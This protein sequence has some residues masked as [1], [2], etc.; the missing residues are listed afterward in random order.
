MH[1]LLVELGFVLERAV[2]GGAGL[3]QQKILVRLVT[4]FYSSQTLNLEAELLNYIIADQKNRT[5]LALLWLTELYAQ[6]E[7]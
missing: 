5:D 2:Q 7:E 6:F 1:S 3:A 4:R